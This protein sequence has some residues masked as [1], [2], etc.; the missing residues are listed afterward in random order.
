MKYRHYPSCTYSHSVL[1][2]GLIGQG[3]PFPPGFPSRTKTLF[4]HRLLW[5]SCLWELNEEQHLPQSQAWLSSSTPP[6]SLPHTLPAERTVIHANYT[7]TGRKK[8]HTH[9]FSQQQ[10]G[11]SIYLPAIYNSLRQGGLIS[12]SH[13]HSPK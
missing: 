9:F 3:C 1:S 13:H 7:V 4:A 12:S 6:L 8:T 11:L 2:M 5:N 10:L